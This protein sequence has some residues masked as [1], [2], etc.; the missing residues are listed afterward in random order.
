MPEQ[1]PESKGPP[2]YPIQANFIAVRELYIKSHVPPN[3]RAQVDSAKFILKTAHS[4][5]DEVRHVIEV[6]AI[7]EYGIETKA[8]EVVPYEL[9][10]HI[11]GQFKVDETHFKKEKIDLW[12]RINAPYIL[13]PYLREHV[14]ALTA[15]GGFDPVLLPLVELPTIKF[16]RPPPVVETP[17]VAEPD[18]KQEAVRNVEKATGS[19]P[20]KGEE[21]LES[22]ELKGQLQEGKA[23]VQDKAGNP[24]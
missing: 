1:T 6:G 5:Y 12:A 19:G 17:T 23:R 14:F 13:Y 3:Q 15:R 8:D 7:I 11:M 24:K 16:V 20:A 4:S 18:E 9:R 22:P 2:E 10:A 21:L